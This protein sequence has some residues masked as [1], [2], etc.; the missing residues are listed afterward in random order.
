MNSYGFVWSP[1]AGAWQRKPG[2]NAWY[3]ARKIAET[4]TA[5]A[6]VLRGLHEG[7][8]LAQP[9]RACGCSSGGSCGSCDIN[10]DPAACDCGRCAS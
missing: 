9:E 3:F 8:S 7:I 2:P 5:T 1:M 4:A 10:H 6:Q